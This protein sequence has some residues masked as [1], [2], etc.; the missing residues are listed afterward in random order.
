MLDF[1]QKQDAWQDAGGNWS[2]CGPVAVAN[3]IWWYDS[4]NEPLPTPPPAINDNYFLLTSYNGGVWDDH[5]TQNVQPFVNDLA[6]LMDT[7]G[8][9]TGVPHN[10]TDVMDMQ[11]GIDQYLINMG[12]YGPYYER[13]VKAPD[14]DWIMQEVERCEDIVLL[15][16]F[17]QEQDAEWKRVGGHYVTT[18]GFNSITSEIAICDPYWDNA[19]AG[20]AGRVQQPHPWPHNS[21]VHNDAQYVSQDVYSVAASAS[22]GGNWS[23]VNYEVGKDI[24][25]FVGQNWAPD[26]LYYQAAYNVSLP[27][28]VEIDYAVDMSPKDDLN[29]FVESTYEWFAGELWVDVHVI[30]PAWEGVI[31][32]AELLAWSEESCTLWPYD[33]YF[34]YPPLLFCIPQ[35]VNGSCSTEPETVVVHLSD[36]AGENIGFVY[37]YPPPPTPSPTPSP[38]MTP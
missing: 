10:G 18:A 23:L 32:D 34:P 30:D 26:L 1:D 38:S 9:R 2:Y 25:S 27:V 28:H 20:G 17:W 16:G 29:A 36:A 14:W 6:W 5:D 7:D 15:L 4:E 31:W 11:C 24:S 12:F 35:T 13:T 3:S 19:E 8:Q 22:P 33:G 21:S 37:S